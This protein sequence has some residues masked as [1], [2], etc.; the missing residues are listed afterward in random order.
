MKP[1]FSDSDIA[2]VDAPSRHVDGPASAARPGRA[3]FVLAVVYLI[4]VIYGSLVPL[5]LHLVPLEQALAKF[6]QLPYLKLSIR[7]RSDL[8][9]NLLLFIPLT[10]LAMGALTRENSRRRRALIAVIVALGAALLSGAVEF[11]QIYFPPRTVS[12]NDIMAE[13]IGGVCGV[14]FWFAFG[15]RLTRWVRG[16]WREQ[17]R[18]RLAVKIL[19]G[20]AVFIVL[21]QLFPFDLTIRMAE[22]Y[23]KLQ[24]SKVV[25]VPFTDTVGLDA[26][27]ALSKIAVMIP[28][29]LLFAFMGRSRGRSISRAALYTCIF[30]SLIE[31]AQLLVYSRYACT[32]DVV[33]GALGGW[34][35]AA[36]ATVFGPGASRPVLDSDFWRLRGGTIKLLATMIWGI[37]MTWRK[38]RP[39]DF[40]WP[41]GGLAEAAGELL[42]TPLARQYSA[43]EF[44]ALTQ[45]VREF[46]AFMILGMLMVRI[47]PSRSRKFA[48]LLAVAI[49]AVVLEGGQLFLA[50]RVGDITATVVG[51][52]GGA[53]GIWLAGGFVS[54]FVSS[55]GQERD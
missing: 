33:Y 46:M 13:T 9:A 27:T 12:Q 44:S 38:W 53:A 48:C 25:I 14:G 19:S 2:A 37:C 26:Y 42:V 5:R 18:S 8:V 51:I 28:I 22:L 24:G 52:S 39:F 17:T 49:I 16:L 40:R 41:D 1:V 47:A 10:F 31:G 3:C 15:G 29:G 4:F 50:T 54:V 32:T 11:A 36:A 6:R 23:R 45:V 21:Y 35:G 34:L 30:A 7:S 20:Y 43:S 55:G